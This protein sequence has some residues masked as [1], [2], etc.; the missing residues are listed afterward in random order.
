MP[1]VGYGDFKYERDESWPII[2]EGWTLGNGWSGPPELGIPITSGKGV[3]DVAVDSNDRVYVFNRDAHPVVVFEADTG[4]FVTSWGEY[5]FKETHG[6]FVDSD[7]N[8]WTTDRQEHVVVKHTK[9][10]Q[11]LLELGVRSWASASVTPYGTHPEHNFLGGPFNMPGGVTIA[12]TGAIF[13]GDGYGNRQVHRFSPKGEFE[14]SWGISGTGEGEFSLVHN[15][16]ID[17]KDRVYVCDRQNCRVQIFDYDGNYID[18]WT[19]V[20]NPGGVYCDRNNLVYVAE[21]GVP[22]GIQ[23]NGLSI[24]TEEGE[25]V[26]RFRGRENGFVQPHGISTDSKGNLYLAELESLDIG[27]DHRISK[28]NKI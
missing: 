22:T 25:L 2:P 19:D 6:I 20:L 3:S 26:S 13:V 17:S 7:D 1:I 23:P 27:K 8:V 5:E 16:D 28:W 12:S 21:Q 24:F 9:H 10:G 14:L 18:S 11:K 15:L 4:K